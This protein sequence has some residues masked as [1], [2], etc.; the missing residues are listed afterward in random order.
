MTKEH[1]LKPGAAN[2]PSADIESVLDAAKKA[3]WPQYTRDTL[4]KLYWVMYQ[5]VTQ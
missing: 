5:S 2:D 3:G 1:E 4:N